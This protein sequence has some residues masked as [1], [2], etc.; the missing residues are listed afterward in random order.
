MPTGGSL[1]TDER[2]EETVTSAYVHSHLRANEQDILKRS[3][4]FGGDLTDDTYLDWILTRAKRFFLV[5]VAAGVPDQIFGIIDDS[6]DDDDLPIAEVA[7]PGLRLSLEPDQALDKRFYK[8]QFKYLARILQDGEHIRYASEETVPVAASGLKPSLLVNKD[9]VDTVRLPTEAKKV[10]IRRKVP[11]KEAIGEELV[12]NEIAEMK[13]FS[14]EHVLS[15]YGSYLQN[16]VVYLL[17][18]PAGDWSLKSFLTDQPKSFDALTKTARRHILIDWPHCLANAVAWLHAN[19]GHH[20]AIRP[21]NVHVTYDF[22]ICL[23]TMEGEGVLCNTTRSDDIEA[24]H[25][26]PPERWKRAVT[27]QSTGS[28]KMSLPSGGRSGRKVPTDPLDPADPSTRRSASTLGSHDR[29]TGAY[30]Y[31]QASKSEFSRLRLSSAPVVT[32]PIV[33][34]RRRERRPQLGLDLVDSFGIPRG[35]PVPSTTEISGD[36]V[37]APS[38][39][40]SASS[41]GRRRTGSGAGLFVA[42]PESRTAV[43]QTWK[44]VQHDSFAADV[45]SLGAVILDILTVLCKRT[46][47]SFVRHRSKNNRNAGRGGG[48]ADASFHANLNQVVSWAQQL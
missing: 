17:S 13:K 27:V 16:E 10:F 39:L 45:F 42:A 8:T 3:L 43:I 31:T 21:S 2:V 7:V 9:G 15:V 22:H 6:F 34:N 4:Y 32:E 29:P 33:T 28:A 25:Y 44:S 40:S 46:F 30:T 24:Y 19:A 47:S 12:L 35:G 20:G 26:A 18:C 23:G 37:R 41:E 48:L 14:H 5:L 38:V 1:W 36:S 11:L